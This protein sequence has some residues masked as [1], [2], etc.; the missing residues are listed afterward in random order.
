MANLKNGSRGNLTQERL[1][2]DSSLHSERGRTDESLLDLRKKTERETD[3]IVKNDRIEADEIRAQNR[4]SVDQKLNRQQGRIE[5]NIE[6]RTEEQKA[7]TARLEVQ[8]KNDDKSVETERLLMDAVLLRERGLNNEY[9]FRMLGRDRKL[10]DDN[11]LQERNQTDFEA[12]RAS[13]RLDVEQSQH[14]QTK[15]ELTTRDE[16]LAIVSH[17]L[18]NPIGAILS[19]AQILLEDESHENLDKG[20]RYIV[21]LIKR[22]AESSLRMISDILDMERVLEGKLQLQLLDHNLNKIIKNSIENMSHAAAAKNIL[23][24]AVPSQLHTSA[25][26]CDLDRINQVMSNLIGNAIKFT[27]EGGSITVKVEQCDNEFQ[28]SIADTGAGIEESK[29]DKIFDRYTQ[30]NNKDRRGLGLGLFI[31][32]MLIEAHRGKIWVTSELK[33]GTTFYYSLPCKALNS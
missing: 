3:E 18:R 26:N 23:L 1:E 15:A 7:V 30:L 5:N 6:V 19:G 27:P 14:I 9:A 24:R 21:E 8:R 10:T 13:S 22:N 28:I 29:I 31:S 12:G 32:K 2:T 16:F 4:T 17:D 11:L 33:K 20:T 25:I